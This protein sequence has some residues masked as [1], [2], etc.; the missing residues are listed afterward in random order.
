LADVMRLTLRR[1]AGRWGRAPALGRYNAMH[2]PAPALCDT[3]ALAALLA[4]A[5]IAYAPSTAALWDFWAHHYLGEHGPLIGAICVWLM[6]RSRQALAAA[7]VQPSPWGCAGLLLCSIA[8][9]IFWRAG[10]E[11]LHVLLLPLIL[12]FAVLAA[13]GW[14][15]AR[16]LAFPLGFLYFAEPPWHVL[17]GPLQ[18]LTVHAVGVI[19]PLVGMP[20]RIA[21]SVMYLPGG[22][23]FE[24]TPLC[25]GVNFLVVGLA[26]AG[27]IGELERASVRRRAALLASMTL[28][29]IIS[30]WVRVLAIMAAGYASGMRNVLVTRGHLL[31][32][33]L[34]F[35]LVMFGFAWFA[36]RHPALTTRTGSV[37]ARSVSSPGVFRGYFLAIGVLVAMPI[38]GRA[39]PA[40]LTAE[41]APIGLRLPTGQT[42]WRGPLRASE[43]PWKPEFVGAHS[44]WHV[45]Y[46]D[47][48]GD[49]VDVI[50]IGYS[51]Q[52]QG[53]E[54]VN[55][56]N[57]LL[58]RGACA[59]SPTGQ[60]G[61]GLTA[62]TAGLVVR[63]VH[64]HIE[65]IVSDARGQRF[66]I[67]WA[68]DIGSRKFVTPLFSQ[69]WYGLRSLR[70]PPY[71]LLFAYRTVC[72][73]S[74]E[75]ARAKLTRFGVSVGDHV[76]VN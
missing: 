49:V 16:L 57:S 3:L 15:V 32:G 46:E 7:P 10:I 20:A 5:L 22:V 74:C 1:A 55:E 40:A 47:T 26:V 58:G 53:R 52:E 66:V 2:Q 38:L 48:A 41:G 64:P 12:F 60:P 67:W 39:V 30:N 68:Y 29:A 11:G 9:V 31:F 56:C 35:A 51:R 71:S 44:E 33:W 8:S 73:P 14:G 70:G 42:G 28:V 17:T 50:A 34:L 43:E 25:S 72:S 54:L 19:A 18:E 75:A 59:D 61:E 37:R 27:L 69:L 76:A 63:G 13:F 36:A 23:T 24:V 45:A 6:L 4:I 21:G 62:L 65:V